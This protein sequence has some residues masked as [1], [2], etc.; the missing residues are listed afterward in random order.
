MRRY[1]MGN[2]FRPERQRRGLIPSRRDIKKSHL[3]PNY[4]RNLLQLTG[5]T[6][7]G[8]GMA[9]QALLFCP[10]DKTARTVTQVL[11][12]LEFTVE[13]CTEP[14]AAVKKLMSQH[15]DAIVVDCDNEQNATLLF[16]SARNS[17]SNQASLAVA[18][19]EGQAGVAK[20]FRIG[21]NLVLTKP[22]NVE[23]SKGTLRVARGLLRK[24]EPGKPAMA[25]PQA[26]TAAAMTAAPAPP[27]KPAVTPPT[28][29]V[30]PVAT[31]P[32]PPRPA[33][34]L[35]SATSAL[36]RPVLPSVAPPVVKPSANAAAAQAAA[37]SGLAPS[38]EI[39][40][41]NDSTRPPAA[42][43][44]P[45]ASK[46]GQ[47]VSAS[48]VM[49]LPFV[50]APEGSA[51]SFT[52]GAATA[53]A[54]AREVPLAAVPETVPVPAP[55]RSPV[56]TPHKAEDLFEKPAESS[57]A[58]VPASSESASSAFTPA[59][60]TFSFGGANAFE[61][62]SGGGKRIVF[63][64]VA[65]MIVCGGAYLGWN[66]FQAGSGHPVSGLPAPVSTSTDSTANTVQPAPQKSTAATRAAISSPVTP[67]TSATAPSA[68]GPT[69]QADDLATSEGS[70]P[71]ETR[72]FGKATNSGSAAA[73]K[74]ASTAKPSETPLVVKGGAVPA[75]R[76]KPAAAEAPAPNIAEI[77]S[78][79]SGGDLSGL[80]GDATSAPK[81]VLQTV[82]ISQGVSQGLLLK[83][84]QP[85][86]PRA[87]LA[88]HIE[89][90]VELMATISKTGEIT[91][92]KVL[93]GESQL[94]RAAADAVK[95]WKYKPYLLNG[96]PVEI[97]TQVTISFKLPH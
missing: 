47:S 26:P 64:I 80:V 45:E 84:V 18:I 17:T 10:D 13:A 42:P 78:A 25:G 9:F 32:P 30:K 40:Q 15:F 22:I 97:H 34:P 7:D 81:P 63:G 12:E 57:H 4:L 93:S 62:S 79:G 48:P 44:A 76:S 55:Q 59:A 5:V 1:C 56:T 31:A 69:A 86:Y 50:G 60:P 83:K 92:V 51:G 71:D 85:I 72:N 96:E 43:S 33:A 27:P 19:V 16:K 61:E 75:I 41:I 73:S 8:F 74:L 29:P 20:A 70:V 3:T 35:K 67:T 23:Q 94:T 38:D 68:T 66:H 58:A 6:Y 91:E 53:A 95:Q 14:F 36:P 54:R 21:A 77:A 52:T 37:S 87:A 88:L 46:A 65:A 49:R 2:R 90:I 24:G 11:S 89:G 39:P 82:N 28:A